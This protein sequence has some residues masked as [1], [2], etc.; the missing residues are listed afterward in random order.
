VSGLN[1][2]MNNTVTTYLGNRE[3]LWNL[4]RIGELS[5]RELWRCQ[6]KV[7]VGENQ[8]MVF[9]RV[10]TIPVLEYW[11]LAQYFLQ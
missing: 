10:R 3:K 8:W 11:V 5:E 9:F 6:E 4:K 2:L 1:L 7:H